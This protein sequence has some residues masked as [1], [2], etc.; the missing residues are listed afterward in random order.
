MRTLA[1]SLSGALVATTALAAP[2]GPVETDAATFRVA[3]VAGGLEHPWA[4]A[5]LP[6]GAMLVTERPGRLR[7]IEDGRLRDEPVAGVPEVHARRQGGLLDVAVD[8]EFERNRQI[9]LSYAHEQEDGETTTRV[10]RARFSPD[11]LSD[12]RVIFEAKPLV[13]SSMHFGSRLAFGNDGSLYVTMGERYSQREKAQDLGTHLGKVLRI[14]KDGSVPKDN[15]FVG[16]EG[17]L[18]EIFTYGHRNPQGLVVDPRDGR[19]WENEHGAK[20]GDEVNILK[21]GANY[22]WPEVAY[23]VNYDGSTIGTGR[24]EAP[25]VEP[26]LLYWDPSIAPAGMAFYLGDRFPGW[27]GDMLVGALKFQLVSRLDLDEQG[28]VVKGERFL[29]GEL[30]R[31]RDVVAGPDGLVYLLTDEDPGALYR[32]EP[33]AEAG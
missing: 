10:M 5:F 6:G 23:G 13:D 1:L 27:R 3:E 26:P 9:Y 15:P 7:L 32:L 17:A 12:Q 31:I 25:G 24:T 18:P 22:G 11:G 29:E 8:P 30:G 21:A 33:V 2:Q 4:V 28:H 20:G 16:R 14:N 19:V